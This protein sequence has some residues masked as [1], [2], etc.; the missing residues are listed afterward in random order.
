[1][2][3]NAADF[4]TPIPIDQP[5]LNDHGELTPIWRSYLFRLDQLFRQALNGPLLDATDDAAAATAGVPINGLYKN[6]SAVMIRVT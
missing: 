4:L 3:T 1:M 2:T 5:L 6:G